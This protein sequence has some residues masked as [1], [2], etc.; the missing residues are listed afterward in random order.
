[1]F[2][3]ELVSLYRALPIDTLRRT[4][5]V[6]NPIANNYRVIVSCTRYISGLH[7]FA[8]GVRT[9]VKKYLKAQAAI[10]GS[11]I[12][13]SGSGWALKTLDLDPIP[14]IT[15]LNV[16]HALSGKGSPKEM[17]MTGRILSLM[18]LDPE[19]S[20]KLCGAP[21]IITL[22]DWFF[23]MDC[24]GFT[25]VY[26]VLEGDSTNAKLP[27]VSCQGQIGGKTPRREVSEIQDL[28]F[29]FNTGSPNHI[30]IINSVSGPP[31]DGVIECKICEARSPSFKGAQTN[32][33]RIKKTDSAWH[34]W[35]KDGA[36]WLMGDPRIAHKIVSYY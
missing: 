15:D 35:R 11:G 9:A 30:A 13:K 12:E 4:D 20:N 27:N 29:V 23:G 24:N 3:E 17:Q 26:Q 10:A 19:Y 5:S 28:D 8:Q 18:L 32:E 33:W 22:A 6:Q 2:P 1:M 25:G 16:L 34:L 21:D 31:K 7:S 36:T 14:L